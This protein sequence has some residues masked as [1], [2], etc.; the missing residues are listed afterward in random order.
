MVANKK[1][2]GIRKKNKGK[3]W[4]TTWM[5]FHAFV[6]GSF[7]F[8]FD[9]ASVNNVINKQDSNRVDTQIEL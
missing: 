6:D 2:E 7:F 5:L 4:F 1:G 9:D 3:S 8:Y